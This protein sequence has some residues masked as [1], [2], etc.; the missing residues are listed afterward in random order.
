L[1]GLT[2]KAVYADKL[3]ATILHVHEGDMVSYAEISKGLHRYIKDHDLKQAPVKPAHE[4]EKD[5]QPARILEV[6]PCRNCG[7]EVSAE[8]A[9]CDMCGA[10]Q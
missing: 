7:R 5:E 2:R 4:G 8:A 3:L 6:K 9:F 10:G 1:S